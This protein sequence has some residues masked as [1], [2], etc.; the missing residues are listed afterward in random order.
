MFLRTQTNLSLSALTLS[1]FASSCSCYQGLDQSC[2]GDD[3]RDADRDGYALCEADGLSDCDDTN[4]NVYPGADESCN[5]IDDDC[6]GSLSEGEIDDDEDTYMIC[7]GDCNDLEALVNPGELEI[8]N[9]VDDNCDGLIP[10]DEYDSDSD[11]QYSGSCGPDCNDED[12]SIYL[13]A[14]ELCDSLDND[15][16]GVVPF[17]EIDNDGDTFYECSGNDCDDTDATVYVGAVELCD[18]LD[19]DCDGFPEEDLDLDGF[20]SCVDQDC[21]DTNASINPTTLEF[22]NG[23][24]ED[25]NGLIDDACCYEDMFHVGTGMCMDRYEAS[26]DPLNPGQ[27]SSVAG[28]LPWVNINWYNAQIA[29][30]SVGK[31]LCT[32]AD[33]V[34]ACG[35]PD[36][37]LPPVDPPNY[38]YG[39]VYDLS[40]CHGAQS[41]PSEPLSFTG[42]YPNCVSEAGGYDLVGNVSEWNLDCNTS[43]C[44]LPGGNVTDVAPILSCN[45]PVS[46]PTHGP[47][48]EQWIIGFRCC[49]PEEN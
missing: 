6:D 5:G 46:N 12:S 43:H 41:G 19:N 8:C 40:V 25:C 26:E 39:P 44:E 9:Q 27:P 13:G 7:Q 14:P 11:G 18:A 45:G 10:L 20:L 42:A 23:V 38:P 49:S 22:C 24:D 30:Q 36:A 35:G 31:D 17:D 28:A 33:L 4:S 47:Y 34:Y 48:A 3:S 29:C 2:V 1:L 32:L 21:D 16:D 37:P 15:C